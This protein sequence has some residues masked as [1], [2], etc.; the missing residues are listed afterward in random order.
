VPSGVT[1]G[2]LAGGEKGTYRAT[3]CPSITPNNGNQC[4]VWTSSEESFQ[5]VVTTYCVFLLPNGYAWVYWT[6]L[7]TF[8]TCLLLITDLRHQLHDARPSNTPNSTYVELRVINVVHFLFSR[9]S[10]AVYVII[11]H[12]CSS[13]DARSYYFAERHDKLAATPRSMVVV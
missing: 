4:R 6:F 3:A 8:S 12:V 11:K 2:T 9:L 10:L 7:A 1:H 5:L 13:R